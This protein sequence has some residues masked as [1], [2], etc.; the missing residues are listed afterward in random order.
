MLC[1]G[2]PFSASASAK[3]ATTVSAAS[4]DGGDTFDASQYRLLPCTLSGAGSSGKKVSS[5][6]VTVVELSSSWKQLTTTTE[7]IAIAA[8][9]SGNSHVFLDRV[10]PEL[11]FESF[12]VLVLLLQLYQVIIRLN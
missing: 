11:L 8:T 9:P 3:P 6:E 5:P 12:T 7:P 1:F 2:I 10:F 4:V